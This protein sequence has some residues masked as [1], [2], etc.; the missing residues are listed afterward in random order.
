MSDRHPHVSD[1]LREKLLAFVREPSFI[2]DRTYATLTEFDADYAAL[3]P[4]SRRDVLESIR[5]FVSMWFLCIVEGRA[6][7]AQELE[8]LAEAGRRRVH[9][10][11]GLNS[12]LRAFR[13]GSKEILNAY[14]EIGREDEALRDEIFF[15]VTPFLLERSD[16]MAQ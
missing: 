16:A 7:N 13:A 15:V 1:R 10:D 14:V 5:L 2:V 12:L 3:A 11:I 4:A 9:Q 6:P 8:L